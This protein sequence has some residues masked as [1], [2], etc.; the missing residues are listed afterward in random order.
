VSARC[1]R[2]GTWQWQWYHDP[3]ARLC[4]LSVCGLLGRG[5]LWCSAMVATQGWACAKWRGAKESKQARWDGS[6]LGSACDECNL[7]VLPWTCRQ[8]ACLGIAVASNGTS[9]VQT[10]QHSGVRRQAV[11]HGEDGTTQGMCVTS[12][13][14]ETLIKVT[15]N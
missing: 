13:I 14:L 6:C 11:P 7:H 12:H 3:D 10:H 5:W 2:G 15:S 4:G 8:V 9:A 1:S